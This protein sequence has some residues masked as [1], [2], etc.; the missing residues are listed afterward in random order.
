MNPHLE[1]QD[2]TFLRYMAKKIFEWN[3]QHRYATLI[4]DEIYLK[5]FFDYGGSAVAGIALNNALVANGAFV[6]MVHSLMSKLEEVKHI[7]P[8]HKANG[9]FLLTVLGVGICGLKK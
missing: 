2:N 9:K 1:H 3:E 8:V 6:F 4:V 7:V 5:P